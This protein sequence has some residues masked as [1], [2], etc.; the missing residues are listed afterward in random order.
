MQTKPHEPVMADEVVQYLAPRPGGTYVDCT[1]GAGGHARRVAEAMGRGRLIGFDK[2]PEALAEAAKAEMPAGV[3]FELVQGDYRGAPEEVRARGVERVDGVV[4]DLG[5]SS[6]QVDH[7]ERGFG[8]AANGPLDMRMDPRQE[9][10]AE[11][12][13]NRM[14]ERELADLIFQYGEERRS[15]RIARAI[16]RSRPLR[17]TAELAEL[18]AAVNRPVNKHGRGLH[19]ATRTFQALRMYVNSE[20]EALTA[21]LAALPAWLAPQGRAVVISFHSLEDRPVKRAFRAGAQRG[22]YKILTPHA[23]RPSEGECR[24]NRRARSAKLR[25]AARI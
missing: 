19:P 20:I 16:V 9:L 2:D 4:A 15:R 13:V 6:M 24:S 11:R 17:S 5:M 7:A 10:T 21:L 14:D 18:V 23:V 3:Q 1:V 25:A 12:V 8:F 22:E